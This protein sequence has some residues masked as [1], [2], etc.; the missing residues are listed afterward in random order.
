MSRKCNPAWYKF[1]RKR[2]HSYGEHTECISVL[3]IQACERTTH[4]M[5]NYV[6]CNKCS[7]VLGGRSI[8]KCFLFDSKRDFNPAALQLDP[9]FAALRKIVLQATRY[10]VFRCFTK[11]SV[12]VAYYKN[13]NVMW[14]RVMTG[15]DERVQCIRS[16]ER[17]PRLR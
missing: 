12:S 3:T 9:F 1:D 6:L 13:V 10:S 17:Q 4:L 15:K 11:A 16:R 14:L 2:E 8:L 5:L 7:V